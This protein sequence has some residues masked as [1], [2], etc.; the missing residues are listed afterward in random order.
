MVLEELRREAQKCIQYK[1]QSATAIPSTDP[2]VANNINIGSNESR[3]MDIP[4]E[5]FNY[6]PASFPQPTFE[7]VRGGTAGV[8]P[9]LTMSNM[10]SEAWMENLMQDGSPGTYMSSLTSWGEFDSLALTGL[11]ELG[12]LFTSNNLQTF[13]G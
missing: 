9:S 5:H 4:G 7:G 11:G 13:E 8:S 1:H 6:G 10:Q 3:R 2:Q 12:Y